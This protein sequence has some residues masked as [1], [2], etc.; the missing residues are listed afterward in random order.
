MTESDWAHWKQLAPRY[1]V[2]RPRRMLALDGGGIRGLITVKALLRLES[3]LAAHYARLT[4]IIPSSFRLCHFFD[5]V[6]GTST[7]AII[8]TA[9]ARGLSVSEII[10]M[11][12]EFGAAAFTKRK[13]HQRW[14]SLYEAE[15]LEGKLKTVFTEEAT[16]EPQHLT[17]LLLI[18]TRNA[19]SDSVWAISSNPD[20]KYNSFNRPDCN[21]KIPLWELVRASAAAPVYFPPKLVNLVKDD[22]SRSVVFVDGATTA[23]NN[24][25][26][27]LARMATD[28]AYRLNWERGENNLLLVSLG[29]GQA[30]AVQ[31]KTEVNLVTTAMDTLN[32]LMSQT[33]FD[34]E[35]NCRTIGRCVFGDTLDEEVGDLI[36]RRNA[37]DPTSQTIPLNEDLGRAFLYARYNVELS[38]DALRALD[39]SHIDPNRVANLDSFKALSELEEI[40]DAM[41]QQIQLEHFGRFIDGQLFAGE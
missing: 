19:R 38:K 1:R 4:G 13:W 39:L 40:G 28:A 26:F 25:A 20:A 22:P 35:I 18:V 14:K 31:R 9:I 11:Y 41:G 2:R 6:A 16:L 32:A 12:R 30:P 15:R 24:P 3:L 33:S 5:Y 21:L 10:S 37:S 8:A 17:T 36:P 23:Y 7:G 34:Q 27:C 29:T